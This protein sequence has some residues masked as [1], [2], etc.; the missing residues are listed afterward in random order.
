MS[1]SQFSGIFGVIIKVFVFQQTAL[2]T[3]QTICLHLSRIKFHLQFHVL[4]HRMKRSAKLTHQD[5]IGFLQ[6]IDISMI[7]IPFFC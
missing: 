2:I 7:S 5:T 4:C 6:I 1:G 3:N